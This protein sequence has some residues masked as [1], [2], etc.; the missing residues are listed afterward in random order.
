MVADPCLGGLVAI[1][2]L[3]MKGVILTQN[4]GKRR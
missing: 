4:S 3:V 1:C 2:I